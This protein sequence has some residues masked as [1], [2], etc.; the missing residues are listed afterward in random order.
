[1]RNIAMIAV[2][3]PLVLA[4]A[5]FAAPAFAQGVNAPDGVAAAGTDVVAYFRA[6]KPVA[7]TPGHTVEWNGAVWRFSSEANRAAFAAD[8]ERYAPRYG[9]FC[10]WAVA[11]GY[12]AGIDPLAWRIVDGR[13]YLNYSRAIRARWDM[14]RTA[15]IAKAD[16]NWPRLAGERP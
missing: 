16:A 8:P 14:S 2:L 9:G 3:R 1:M 7:G 15:N 11:Q 12:R 10:A 13:L 6:G 5:L 4:F